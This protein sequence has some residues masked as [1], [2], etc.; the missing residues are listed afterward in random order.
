MAR[1]VFEAQVTADTL[2]DR[3]IREDRSAEID[4][5]KPRRVRHARPA[6]VALKTTEAKKAQLMRLAEL[7]RRPQ[8]EVFEL[9]L[10][11]LEREVQAELKVMKAK[12]K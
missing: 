10:D 5:G 3:L 11:A 8:I 12:R 7:M 1:N 9:A 6:Q 2:K 4:G